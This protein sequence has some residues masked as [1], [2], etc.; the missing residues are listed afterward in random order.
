[1]FK[2]KPKITGRNVDRSGQ[3]GAPV[4]SYYSSRSGGETERGRFEAPKN[5]RGLE[6]LKHLPTTLAIVLIV[7]CVVYASLLNSRPRIMIAASSTGKPL[8]R[9]TSVY[10]AYITK[11]LNSSILNKS[12]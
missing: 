12:K 6:R 11:Q 1:M 5:Q 2:G 8:Q 3:S 4:F 7:G 9:P 10:E